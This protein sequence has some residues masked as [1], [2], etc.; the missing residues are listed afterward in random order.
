MTELDAELGPIAF[1][2]IEEFGKSVTYV[3]NTAGA[4]NPAT[5]EAVPTS[6]PITIKA[7][8]EDTKG[9][10]LGSGLIEAA[11]KKL[12]VSAQYFQTFEPTPLDTFI[13]DGVTYTVTDNGIK[14]TYSGEL[15]CLYE[16]KGA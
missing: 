13:V 15:V 11:D 6:D 12:T 1:D 5:S 3:R 2:A 8:V 14:K 4:Y 10:Y 7:L 16:I 9:T